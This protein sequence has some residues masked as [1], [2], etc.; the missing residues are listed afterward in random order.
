MIEN[1]LRDKW[2][3]RYE[4]AQSLPCALEVLVENSHLLPARGTALD[5]ACGLGGSGLLLAERGLQTWAWDLSPVAI[6][7]LERRAAGL[8]LNAETRDVIN[9]PPEPGRFDVICVGHFLDRELCKHIA[10]ALKPGGLLF[11]QTFSLERVDET[12]PG[13]ARYRLAA[14]ELLELFPDL[15]VRFYRDEGC[16]GDRSRGFRNRAQ[17][18]AE[19]PS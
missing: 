1:E 12:G 6:A 16:A 5:L 14:N 10:A 3:R 15:M 17:L 4:Q 8:P 18:V 9:S 13:T 7:A 19:Q 2:D 11:Y